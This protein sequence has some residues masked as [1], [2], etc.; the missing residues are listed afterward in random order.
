MSDEVN[1]ISEWN[2]TNENVDPNSSGSEYIPDETS[3]ST[4]YESGSDQTMEQ[5]ISCNDEL[6]S[7]VMRIRF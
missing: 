5:E 2:D 7:M 1:N 3:E 6:V 4:T